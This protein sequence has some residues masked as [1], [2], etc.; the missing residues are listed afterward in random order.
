[1][2]L[3]AETLDEEVE[4]RAVIV[5]DEEGSHLE[6]STS[7]RSDRDSIITGRGHGAR[8]APPGR[9]CYKGPVPRILVIAAEASADAH[10]AAVVR[11]LKARRPDLD[12]F[13]LAGPRLRELGVEPLARAEDLSVMGLTE[14]LGALPRIVG[15]MRRLTRAAA[16]RRPD[17]A[18]LVDSPDLNLR[19]AKRL[20]RLGIPVLYFIGPTVW[21]WR[22]GRIEQIRRYV[23]RMLVILPFEEDVYRA[24]GVAATYVGHPL[25]DA[26]G[27]GGA[28]PSPSSDPSGLR[29]DLGL[30]PDRT[31]L[32]LLPGSRRMEIARCLP[33]MLDA[34]DQL[35][36]ARDLQLVLPV[37][38]TLD[39][40]VVEAHL[41]RHPG[42][43]V[44]LVDGRAREVLAAGDV[45][46]VASGT[47]TLEAALAE[48]PMV[49]VYR[50]SWLT[51]LFA[52][53]LVRTAHVALVNLLAGR[54]L[55][56]ELLQRAMRPDAIAA[57]VRSLLPGG[58]AREAVLAGL[59]EVR[60]R[61]GGPGASARV[62]DEAARLLAPSAEESETHVA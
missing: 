10:A 48:K 18:L 54:R 9:K 4:G 35:A 56:P 57:Q 13:G 53:L 26:P 62:A 52:R 21:A 12:A 23:D 45:A 29:R 46:V 50:V 3:A 22:R 15:I 37:A 20:H 33:A 39:R 47:A 11:H 7:S 1:M 59:R 49:V 31:T 28:S 30:D 51:W 25:L 19:M 58:E 34:A 6:S 61:L 40:A 42:L 41:A 16:E 24:A 38:P 17:L 27:E 2:P 60:A 44:H 5:G 43:E 55:V 36:A 32:A 14:V 8:G